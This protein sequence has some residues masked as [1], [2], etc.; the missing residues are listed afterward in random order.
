M[1][2]FSLGLIRSA[3][4]TAFFILVFLVTALF[5]G[6]DI[7]TFNEKKIP[8]EADRFVREYIDTLRTGDVEAAS[9][10][11]TP[12]ILTPET[13]EGLKKISEDISPGE[14]T[15]MQ[16]VQFNHH[17]DLIADETRDR[18]TYQMRLGDS[19]FLVKAIV[20]G[21]DGVY[22]LAAFYV[23]PRAES[24]KERNVF[25]FRG[26]SLRQ[27]FV[28]FLAGAVPVFILCNAYL[29]ARSGIRH[30]WIWLCFILFG[31][32]SYSVDWTSGLWGFSLFT[33]SFLGAAISR[34]GLDGPWIVSF[35]LPVGAIIYFIRYRSTVKTRR[36]GGFGPPVDSPPSPPAQSRV[37]QGSQRGENERKDEQ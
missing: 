3:N 23:E 2:Y 33:F 29:C 18:L 14:L 7:N 16:V 27:Y 5:S 20:D 10:F 4:R 26:K 15:S 21:V 17:K 8:K 24:R 32:S 28:L 9:E 11:L 37:L 6:C 31:F 35:Y 30:R 13:L 34:N 25:D 36:T 12:S 19:W 1:R 22:K